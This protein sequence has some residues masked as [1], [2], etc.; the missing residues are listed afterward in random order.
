MSNQ[1]KPED[2]QLPPRPQFV[3]SRVRL[4]HTVTGDP[5][6]GHVRAEPG[7]YECESNQWGAVSVTATNGEPLGLRPAEF[8]VLENIRNPHLDT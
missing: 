2:P 8:D 6:F 7:D 1:K 3:P 4:L 5:P